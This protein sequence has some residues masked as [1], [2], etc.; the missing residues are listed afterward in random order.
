MQKID[1]YMPLYWDERT[2]SLW[3]EI[4]TFDTELLFS[5]GLTAGL[6][7]NDIGLDRGQSGQGRVVKFQRVGPRVLMVQPNYTFRASS[8]ESGRT[9]CGRGRV[10]QVDPLGLHGRG[11]NR[12]ARARRCDGLL[13]ARCP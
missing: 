5:T 3:M 2:G 6:G 12:P 4:D 13:P 11:R 8:R 10:C 7:S 1:G 9:A